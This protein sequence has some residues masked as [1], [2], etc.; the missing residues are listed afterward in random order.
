M[1]VNAR[2]MFKKGG[3]YLTYKHKTTKPSKKFRKKMTNFAE[4]GLVEKEKSKSF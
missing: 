1:R 2:K 3:D 4:I